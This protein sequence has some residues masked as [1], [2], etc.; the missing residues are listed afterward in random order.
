MLW[1]MAGAAGLLLLLVLAV[2]CGRAAP[3]ACVGTEVRW[4]F[5]HMVPGPDRLLQETIAGTRERLDLA[6]Y[7]LTHAELARAVLQAHGRGVAVRL[8]TDREQA[9][10][11]AQAAVLQ[12]FRAAG[13]P[14]R[15]NTHPG[16]MH[17]KVAIADGRMV[18]F[19]SF[20]V[21]EAAARVNDEVLAVVESPA[22]ARAWTEVFERLWTDRQGVRDWVPD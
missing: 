21:T 1:R 13:I 5:T 8:L 9:R 19:G 11:P 10:N 14:V 16:L 17:L 2:A 6:V 3:T 22:L 4:A 18:A 20:N 7:A 15:V 12:K